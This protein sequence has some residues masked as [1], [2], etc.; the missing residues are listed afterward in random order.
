MSH[1]RGG[2]YGAFTLKQA[3]TFLALVDRGITIEPDAPLGTTRTGRS[4][5]GYAIRDPYRP[6][7][8]YTGRTPRLACIAAGFIPLTRG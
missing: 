8:L 7:S 5:W 4:I 2:H 1:Y 3:Q 6:G